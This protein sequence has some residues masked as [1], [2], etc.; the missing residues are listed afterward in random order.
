MDSQHIDSNNREL[1][2]ARSPLSN[3]KFSLIFPLFSCIFAT[4]S[5]KPG[6]FGRGIGGKLKRA[7]R[8]SVVNRA[9]I[10]YPLQISRLSRASRITLPKY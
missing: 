1:Y 3:M 5:F 8:S 10:A 6:K 9:V 4:F 7:T 2:V